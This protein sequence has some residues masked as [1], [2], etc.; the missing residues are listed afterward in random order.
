MSSDTSP[1]SLNDILGLMV[2]SD[3]EGVALVKRAYEFAEIAHSNQVRKSGEPYF[4]HAVATACNL[5]ELGLDA[6]T[7]TAGLLHDTIEDADISR[8]EIELNFGE[9]VRFLVDGVTKLGELKYHGDDRRAESLRKLFLAMAQDIRVLI[10]KL[11]DRLHN[12]KTLQHVSSEK[13]H[14]IAVET[15]EIYAP[16]ANRLGMGKLQAELEDGAF[17]YAEPEDAERTTK[18]FKQQGKRAEKSLEKVYK[19]LSSELAKQNINAEVSYR[20]KHLYS[21]Y[22]K[23]KRKEW[24]IEKVYDVMALRVMAS[25]IEDC[26]RI[27]G[28][29]HAHWKPLPGRIKDYIAVPKPNGYQSIHTTVFTGDGE[30]AEIQIRTKEMHDE[31]EFG[32]AAHLAYK[33]ASKPKSGGR[34]SKKLQWVQQLID[35]QKN[36]SESRE[37]IENL[38]LDFFQYRVFTFTPNGDVIELPED[39]TPIDF[40]YAVHSELGDR[41]SGAKIN[42]KLASLSTCLKN[43]DIV[44]IMTGK[45]HVPSYKWLDFTKTSQARKKIRSWLSKNR[46]ARF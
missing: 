30:I 26:Y 18:L 42:G 7:I 31:S 13:Q 44:E 1:P 4:I 6:Q 2:S 45:N 20:L 40:A 3:P 34:L 36:F 35:W 46:S 32:I 22:K 38:K 25:S 33:E 21:L 39:A 19:S 41:I 28:I 29:I 8:A 24:N 16:L 9:T 37:F 27:L 12:I 14:R 15:L 43:G 17:L 10:I 23:L 11:A 5:A